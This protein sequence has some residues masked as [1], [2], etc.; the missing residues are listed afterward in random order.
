MLARIKYPKTKR[1]IQKPAKSL[2][3]VLNGCH[4]QILLGPFFN[5]LSQMILNKDSPFTLKLFFSPC[6]LNKIS[7][8]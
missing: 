7:K 6:D 3:T 1:F 4:P 8:A 2:R 5:T